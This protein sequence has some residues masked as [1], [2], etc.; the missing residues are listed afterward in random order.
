VL[1]GC[2]P[3][4]LLLF[5]AE[6]APEIAGSRG[7]GCVPPQRVG[8]GV[9]T[10]AINSAHTAL[11]LNAADAT[12]CGLV[13]PFLIDLLPT[14][15]H[16]VVPAIISTAQ[17]PGSPGGSWTAAT[18][19]NGTSSW[20]QSATSCCGSATHTPTHLPSNGGRGRGGLLHMESSAEHRTLRG[21]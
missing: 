16:R 20:R 7:F 3:K 5:A 4:K 10:T 8:R 2:V 17:P 15:H 21:R 1:R 13:C 12:S 19:C 6:F 11:R 9:K 18:S 14:A